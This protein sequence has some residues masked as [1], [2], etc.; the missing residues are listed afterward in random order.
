MLRIITET[1]K[2]LTTTVKIVLKKEMLIGW[3]IPR[4]LIGWRI[5]RLLIGWRIPRL[6]LGWRIPSLSNSDLIS[7]GCATL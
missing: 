3:R 1:R 6:Y 4:L 7:E 2:A 5:P